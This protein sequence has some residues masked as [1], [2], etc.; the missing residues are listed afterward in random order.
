[1]RFRSLIRPL[2]RVALFA[3]LALST[4]RGFTQ[5]AWKDPRINLWYFRNLNS[6]TGA[7]NL[8]TL[9][10]TAGR[11][12][13]HFL[14]PSPWNEEGWFGKGSAIGYRLLKVY[15]V[16]F[17]LL[18]FYTAVPQ[19]EIFGHGY[20]A[21]EFG[22]G[23]PSYDFSPP[24]P[25]G[26]G[27][28]LT[29]FT[30]PPTGRTP[31]QELS[32]SMGGVE[33]S[34]V[35]SGK[36][37]RYWLMAGNMDFHG[38]LLYMTTVGDLRN[39]LDQT[40]E[41]QLDTDPDLSNDML[42]YIK[43][44]NAKV[45]RTKRSNFRLHLSQMKKKS[46]IAFADPFLW[47]SYWTVL[48]THIWSGQSV[49]AYPAIPLG[50][51]RYLPLLGYG[52]TLWGPEYQF[53]NMLAL[54]QRVLTFRVRIGDDTFRSSWG[55]DLDVLNVVSLLGFDFD[56]GLHL[57]K[58]PRLRLNV[59]DIELE[60]SLYGGGGSLDM[61]SPDLG[62]PFPSRLAGGIDYKTSGFTPGKDLERGPAWRIG[63]NIPL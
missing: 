5:E 39:Y 52:L 15:F 31:D 46:A 36:I 55:T 50:P 42:N 3:T 8:L 37:R 51:V 22:F 62:M 34:G 16:D 26:E 25:F 29:T 56:V 60:P 27:T 35:M 59:N 4:S 49:F 45:D 7:D 9:H 53:D 11:I 18:V 33:A 41:E 2:F 63:L 44:L 43:V 40:D 20:R 28:G 1:M 24:P 13:D 19:H 47:Y 6:G 48:K 54:D 57:W 61:F 58:Q 17:D 23:D 32:V 10:Y 38:S 21:R 14:K 30:Y 12:E